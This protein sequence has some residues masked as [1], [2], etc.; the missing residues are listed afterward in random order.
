MQRNSF[1]YGVYGRLITM[2]VTP[3]SCCF[4]LLTDLLFFVSNCSLNFHCCYSLGTPCLSL[5]YFW[6]TCMMEMMM[7]LKNPL[8]HWLSSNLKKKN[9]YPYEKLKLLLSMT[10]RR[11]S[12]LLQYWWQNRLVNEPSKPHHRLIIQISNS[13]IFE[14]R[15]I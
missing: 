2:F 14:F 9:A 4:T 7:W 8:T 15:K 13:I 5:C 1:E 10:F 11:L 6:K 12:D 3:N